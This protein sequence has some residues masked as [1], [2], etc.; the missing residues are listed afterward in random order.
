[1]SDYLTKTL[2]ELVSEIT[3]DGRIDRATAI[4]SQLQ[5]RLD[6]HKI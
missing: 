2:S 1:M 6:L 4:N 5:F 3:A